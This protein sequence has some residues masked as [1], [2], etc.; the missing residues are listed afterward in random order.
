MFRHVKNEFQEKLKRDLT[1]IRSSNSL[2]VFADKTKNIYKLSTDQY[3]KLLTENITKC[4][5]KCDDS[6]KHKIDKET[7]KVAKTLNL[8]S[9]MEGY[10]DRNSYN[11]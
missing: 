11:H 10:V 9:K 6:V 3:E 8:D 5:Q 7:Q 4:Y 2:F 1:E